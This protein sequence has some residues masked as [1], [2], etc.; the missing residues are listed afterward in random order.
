[1]TRV[2]KK[3]SPYDSR[4]PEARCTKEEK[5][6]IVARAAQSGLSTSEFLR[7]S[8]LK[9][10]VVIKQTSSDVELTRQLLAIGN[11]LNQYIK[12]AHI[13]G[14]DAGEQKLVLLTVSKLETVLDTLLDGA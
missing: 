5:A 2:R 10:K 4:L 3:R 7:R 9:S 8:A 13:R 12:R 1:M 6:A 11:N 14:L